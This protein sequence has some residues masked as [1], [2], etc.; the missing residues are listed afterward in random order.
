MS[1]RHNFQT[2][3][4]FYDIAQRGLLNLN[5]PYQR[6]SVWNQDFKDYFVETVLMNYPAPAIF[7]FEDIS[8]DGR[9]S[10]NVVDGKQRLTTLLEFIRG[11][12]PVRERGAISAASGK[13]FLNLDDAL[14][15]QV[16]SYQFLVEYVPSDDEEIINGIFDRINRNVAK[17][18]QQELR[19]ARL[20]GEFITAAEDQTQWL[21]ETLPSMPRFAPQSKKQMKDV[22]FVALLFLLLEDGPK[23][24]SQE[25]LDEAFTARDSE[26]D[27]R[28]QTV[29]NFQRAINSVKLIIF[30]AQDPKELQ[31]SRLRNQADFYSLVGAVH[32]LLENDKLAPFDV[33]A[34]SLASFA[35]RVEVESERLLDGELM[36]YFDAARSASNDKGPRERRINYMMQLLSL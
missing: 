12:F 17:L 26:W 15:K 1:R 20:D 30:S 25:A 5:P 28:N 6:R 9:S 10:Y 32:N 33:A 27:S 18:T 34:K 14:K 23:G 36:A 24:Y 16:W 8:P 13:Y 2:V 35:S 19:H 7:L 4:W 29:S 22:E 11:D 31:G 21:A 3:S